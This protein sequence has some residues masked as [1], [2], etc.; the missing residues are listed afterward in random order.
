MAI[1]PVRAEYYR[2]LS[3]NPH[4]LVNWGVPITGLTIQCEQSVS[5]GSNI[6]GWKDRIRRGVSATTELDGRYESVD[7][8]VNDGSAR[9]YWRDPQTNGTFFHRISEV[10]GCLGVDGAY[11]STP[12]VTEADKA[13]ANSQALS[14]FLSE[15]HEAQT[16]IQ[17]LV[18]LGE[19][20]ETLR[21]LR[22]PF[23]SLFQLLGDYLGN[24][25]RRTRG[26]RQA[27]YVDRIVSDTWLET[28]FGV[29]PLVSDIQSAA[30]A[31][32]QIV[33]GFEPRAPIRGKAV[34]RRQQAL[35]DSLVTANDI[36]WTKKRFYESEASVV[37]HGTMKV[38][39][40]A[41]NPRWF[42]VL[43]LTWG[44]FLP[45][46]WELI[47]YSFLADYFGNFSEIIQ[48]LKYHITDFGF[49]ERSHKYTRSFT[50]R[51]VDLRT[52][53]PAS[54]YELV[55]FERQTPRDFVFKDKSVYRNAYTGSLVPSFSF[56]IPGLGT[57][58]LN[59]AALFASSR[60]I[61]R[62]L[63]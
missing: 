16:Q 30:R 41:N 50:S 57:R 14:R 36:K 3:T 23:K 37:Y 22:R 21:M 34:I 47:P 43:G 18:S 49:V 27:R 11:S 40:F 10:K 17:S 44:D 42:E 33:N 55:S 58:W 61:Q 13:A 63:R 52:E 15:A 6:P 4:S 53:K 60:Q 56:E 5:K 62:N 26:R 19:L 28:Q 46:L 7:P 24:V 35:S 39:P 2:R 38:G 54:G 9:A 45:T 8:N 12:A 20:G 25:D 51:V 59:M 29:K 48:S 31:L 1:I 32:S